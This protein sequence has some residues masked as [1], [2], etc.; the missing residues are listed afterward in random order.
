M[1]LSILAL[2]IAGLTGAT[3]LAQPMADPTPARTFQCIE[4]GGQMAP[5]V[6][7]VTASRIHSR[8]NI[9][10]CPAGGQR[11]EVA[12]CAKG[13]TPPA[14]NKALHR[15]RR[16]AARDGSLIG[17]TVAGQPICAAPRKG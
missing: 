17:D 4:P 12:V 6:C 11:V 13:Q 16:K 2:T 7:D 8:E 5:A 3:A 15:I 9:C 10:T 14:D 1:R